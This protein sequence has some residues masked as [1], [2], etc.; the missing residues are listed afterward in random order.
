MVKVVISGK[1]YDWDVTEEGARQ[2]LNKFGAKQISIKDQKEIEVK[3]LSAIDPYTIGLL[4]GGGLI[5]I[6]RYIWYRINQKEMLD[7]KKE[8][9]V[10]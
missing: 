7:F 1:I 10:N 8:Y 5:G 3:E 2:I 4:V 6:G 9:K